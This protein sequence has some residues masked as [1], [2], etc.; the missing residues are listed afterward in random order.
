MDNASNCNVPVKPLA[1]PRAKW[2]IVKINGCSLEIEYNVIK[3]DP[4]CG[5]EAGIEIETC[6]KSG[7]DM[8]DFIEQNC[9]DVWQEI[10]AAILAKISE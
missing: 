7:E 10:E 4:E 8:N 6:Y 3:G 5:I 1:K 2:A 9:P